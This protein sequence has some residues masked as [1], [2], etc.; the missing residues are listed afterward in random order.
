MDIDSMIRVAVQG[1]ELD[2]RVEKSS[3]VCAVPPNPRQPR[4]NHRV[5]TAATVSVAAAV[6]DSSV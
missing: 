4:G 5:L 1:E 6:F 3:S 2:C